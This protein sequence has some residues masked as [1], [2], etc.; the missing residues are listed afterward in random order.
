MNIRVFLV[1]DSEAQAQ[2]ISRRLMADGD[3]QVVGVAET[4]RDCLRQVPLLRPDVVVM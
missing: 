4:G 3:I 2:V 1:E